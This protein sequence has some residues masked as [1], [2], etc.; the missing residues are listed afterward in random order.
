MRQVVFD[1]EARGLNNQYRIE[2]GKLVWHPDTIFCIVAMDTATKKKFVFGEGALANFPLSRFKDF[3][4]TVDVLIAHNAFGYDLPVLKA[5]LGIQYE[6]FYPETIDTPIGLDTV[7]GKKMRIVDTLLLSKLLNPDRFP[8]HSLANFGRL[9]NNFKGEYVPEGG[10][11]DPDLKLNKDML[12]YCIQD[13]RLTAHVFNYLVQE[14]GGGLKWLLP[15]LNLESAVA[16]IIEKQEHY[17]FKFD[18][19]KC[20]SNISELNTLL[21]DIEGRV[22][23]RLPSRK[24]NKGE[25]DEWTP[26][27]N[28]VNTVYVYPPK[29][30]LKKD[31]SYSSAI[32]SL[33]EKWEGQ[34]LGNKR[35]RIFDKD[36][37]LPVD[38]EVPLE[39][40]KSPSA[41]MKNAV[42]RWGGTWVDKLIFE[43]KGVNYIAGMLPEGEPIIDKLPMEL[44][45]Q[46]SIKGFLVSQGWNPTVWKEKDLTTN[47]AKAKVSE[48]QYAA[49]VERY[50]E[51]T[52]GSPFEALRCQHLKVSPAGLKEKLMK[53][54]LQK[55][56]KVLSQPKYTINEEKEICPDLLALG[57]KVDYVKDIV[58][59]LTYRHRRNTCEGLLEQP[60]IDIDGRISTPADT[61]GAASARFTHKVVANIPRVTSPYGEPMRALFGVD[62]DRVQIGCDAS[63][64]EARI[65]GHFCLQVEKQ[66]QKD[67]GAKAYAA[68]LTADKPNSV[69]CVNARK[70]GI[71]RQDAKPLKYA[72]SYGAQIPKLMKMYGWSKE[73]ATEV[74]NSFWEASLPL[75]VYKEMLLKQWEM[76]G[77]S[78]IRGPDGRKLITRA[79]YSLVNTSFQHTGVLCMKRAMVWW[80]KHKTPDMHQQIAYHD[81]SVIDESRESIRVWM[82]PSEEQAKAFKSKTEKVS[83]KILSEIIHKGDKFAVVYSPAGE[84]AVK[85]IKFG[86]EFYK[87]NV[88]LTSGYLVG[89]NWSEIH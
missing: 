24:L 89:K 84:L 63:A 31:G 5:L 46:E 64:L 57:T 6:V 80:D 85:S 29:N 61:L 48:E 44:P 73:K 42:E 3:L 74:F 83:G 37:T 47:T 30:Q 58:H 21:S 43:V 7:A 81:E 35:I 75:K 62:K 34:L 79:E 28:Q 25:S 12:D 4:Q 9:L 14:A 41:H 65:E 78:F 68:S 17:G 2:N 1:I 23:P 36:I 19:E 55:P 76:N 87:L 60:R 67:L 8:G 33:C 22:H 59:W 15:A 45:D 16:V 13:V 77:K 88:E 56:L 66:L 50:V 32:Q 20:L 18:K 52:L 71:S 26:P 51:S 72:V 53:H 27:K 69:H 70:M 11:L 10:W 38:P 82:Y 49:I 86:G 40:F 54:D 39:E